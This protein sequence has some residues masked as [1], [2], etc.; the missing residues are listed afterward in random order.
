MVDTSAYG[1]LLNM[2][3]DDAYELYER[4]VENKLCGRWTVKIIEK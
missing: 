2:P 4:I 1:S 3:V